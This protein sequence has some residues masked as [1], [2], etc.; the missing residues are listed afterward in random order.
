MNDEQKERDR[1]VLRKGGA[2][3]QYERACNDHQR[4]NLKSAIK[5]YFF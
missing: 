4:G 2:K 5:N 1:C 3:G